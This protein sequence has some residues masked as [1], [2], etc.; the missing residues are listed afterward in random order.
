MVVF[1]EMKSAFKVMKATV[2]E[3]YDNFAV[4]V[5]AATDVNA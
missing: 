4:F 3:F 2:N 1:W 5:E